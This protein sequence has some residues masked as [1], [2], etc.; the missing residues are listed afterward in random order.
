MLTDKNTVLSKIKDKPGPWFLGKS[1]I[2][3]KRTTYRI[4]QFSNELGAGKSITISK[5]LYDD[6]QQFCFVPVVGYLLNIK[7]ITRQSTPIKL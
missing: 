7:E 4:Y 6:L 3:S 5:A 1:T 2:T